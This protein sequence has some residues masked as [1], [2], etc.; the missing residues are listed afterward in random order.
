MHLLRN[1]TLDSDR[2]LAKFFMPHHS[3]TPPPRPSCG[4]YD[5]FRLLTQPIV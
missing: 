4:S 3:T 5:N 2:K 1:L